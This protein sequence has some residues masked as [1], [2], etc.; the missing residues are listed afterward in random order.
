MTAKPTSNAE[1]I[2][3]I[4]AVSRS[5]R[6]HMRGALTPFDM[7]PALARALRILAKA[8][9]PIRMSELAEALRIERRSATDVVEQLA[10]R[11]LIERHPD[12]T[13]KRATVVE[14]TADGHRMHD[15]IAKIRTSVSAKA[16]A[17]LDDDEV[18]ELHRLL[19]KILDADG[20]SS[21]HA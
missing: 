21:N 18:A 16:A 19:T 15:A 3:L 9:D 8:P 20:C 4:G 12:A 11:G 1:T 6:R 13:D 2:D 10:A 7:P 5:I 14:L 17:P